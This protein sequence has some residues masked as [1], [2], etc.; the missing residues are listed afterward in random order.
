LT[1]VLVSF[2]AFALFLACMGL[3]G[4]T[5]YSVAR[6]TN[7]I[8]IRLALGAQRNMVLWM[9]MRQVAMLVAAGIT[10]GLPA[11]LLGSRA[12]GSFLFG[13]EP[14]DPWSVAAGITV[15]LVAAVAGGLVPA[16]RA[17]RLDPLLALRRE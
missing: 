9:V 6:R 3:H 4:I 10:L 5:A 7:E 17:S 14:G 15:L 16:L 13:V 12:A 8:G 1:T 2:G 11:A